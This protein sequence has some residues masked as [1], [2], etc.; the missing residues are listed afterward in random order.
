MLEHATTRSEMSN[1]PQKAKIIANIWPGGVHGEISPYPIVVRV[2][3]VHH[4]AVK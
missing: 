4:T 3:T 1:A 2:T